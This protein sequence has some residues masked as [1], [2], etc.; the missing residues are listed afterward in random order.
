M[1]FFSTLRKVA[2][3]LTRHTRAQSMSPPGIGS[4]TSGTPAARR[5]S[6]A[7]T[8]SYPLQ[9]KPLAMARARMR[10]MTQAETSKLNAKGIPPASDAWP[11]SIFG[12]KGPLSQTPVMTQTY[13]G[14]PCQ[15][16]QLRGIHT[17][18][19]LPTQVFRNGMASGGQWYPEHRHGLESAAQLHAGMNLTVGLR[20]AKVMTAPTH[21]TVLPAAI[22]LTSNPSVALRFGEHDP[23][24]QVRERG[25][26]ILYAIDIR[27]K[28]DLVDHRDI[29]QNGTVPAEAETTWFG[30]IPAQCVVG[31]Y[32]SADKDSPL[33]SVHEPMG[34]QW[35][36]NPG[37]QPVRDGKI[38]TDK[39]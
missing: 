7:S 1:S 36:P 33:A 11:S 21:L 18:N 27:H 17:A 15:A 19:A 37:Y 20:R 4:F 29:H 30:D 31:Y 35:V 28:R 22:S 38:F 25:Q 39:S 13:R 2:P 14:M 10:A 3:S 26:A 6:Y 8:P 32:K 12:P 23:A 16:I 9:N 34:L 24:S 5:M